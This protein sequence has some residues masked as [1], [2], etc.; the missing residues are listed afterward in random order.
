MQLCAVVYLSAGQG[1]SAALQGFFEE[2]M[3]VKWCRV[4][5]AVLSFLR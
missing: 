1:D 4:L 2:E 5:S 3:G